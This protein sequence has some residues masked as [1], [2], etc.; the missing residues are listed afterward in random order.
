VGVEA[1]E[2]TVTAA[3]NTSAPPAIPVA[4][5]AANAASVTV[6][7]TVCCDRRRSAGSVRGIAREDG[8]EGVRPDGQR[9]GAELAVAGEPASAPVPICCAPS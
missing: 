3:V 6:L 4:G 8:G 1:P 5:A 9:R 7:L 2:L